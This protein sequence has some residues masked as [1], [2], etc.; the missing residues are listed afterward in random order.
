MRRI[1]W[2]G[3]TETQRIVVLGGT[4]RVATCAC[5][6]AGYGRLGDVTIGCL[7]LFG[8]AVVCAP[9]AIAS[10]AVEMGATVD[11]FL[12]E[13]RRQGGLAQRRRLGSAVI[14]VFTLIRLLVLP[15][16]ARRHPGAHRLLKRLAEGQEALPTRAAP[17]SSGADTWKRNS[18]GQ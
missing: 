6:C 7:G 11:D 15:R 10:A 8:L 12:D 4:G 2:V 13:P 16:R 3:S 17:S 5:T 9:A 14:A 18:T 1:Y